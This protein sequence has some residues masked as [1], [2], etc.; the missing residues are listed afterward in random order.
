MPVAS[1]QRSPAALALQAEAERR[2][3]AVSWAPVEL[4][5]EWRAGY[6]RWV[7]EGREAGLG[8]LARGLDVRLDP[9][10]RFGWATSVLLL[11]APYD[12]RDPGRPAGGLRAGRVGRRFWVREPDPF[13]LKRLFEPDVVALKDLA[14]RLGMRARDTVEQG[15]LPLN[16]YAASSG[17]FWRG[18]NAMPL[19][20]TLG[21]RVTLVCLLTDEPPP[22]PPPPRDRCGSCRRCVTACPTGALLGDGRVDLNR[23]VSYWTTRHQDV[24]PLEWWPAI[25]SW[26]F[27]CDLCQDVCPWT[28]RAERAG[29]TWPGFQAEAD[30]AHPDLA[31]FLT[32]S[33][34]AFARKY[35][36]TAFER[37]GRSRMARNALVVLANGGD[38]AHRGLLELAAEDVVPLVRATAAQAL[39][40]S[41][42]RRA[43]A[44]LLAD[45][46]AI[47]RGAARTALE[48]A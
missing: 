13:L 19:S 6:R 33:A 29:R 9:R 20:Q 17:T 3:F 28:A 5:D 46:D 43:A 18:R 25:G 30:L 14:R 44:R 10:Q 21:G 35:A 11:A 1:D 41:G 31:D 47:V 15:P 32:L 16:L 42:D 8:H 37:A 36:S 26:L 22:A 24:L 39:A 2:G 48:A 23:C 27:G 12:Y 7:A 4:P 40:V 45:P 38:A 34:P